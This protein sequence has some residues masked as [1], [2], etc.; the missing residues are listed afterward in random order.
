VYRIGKQEIQYI[1]LQLSAKRKSTS[2]VLISLE[3]FSLLPTF[4]IF[5]VLDGKVIFANF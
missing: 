4:D 3:L 5:S 1:S 2:V